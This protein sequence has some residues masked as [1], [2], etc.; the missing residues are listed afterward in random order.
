MGRATA[1]KR[2]FAFLLEFEF[3]VFQK[4]G[5]AFESLPT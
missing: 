3:V 2:A 4:C 1:E 5:E